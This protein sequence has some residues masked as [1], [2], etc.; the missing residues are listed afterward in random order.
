VN[1]TAEV[2]LNG[3]RLATLIGPN[4]KVIIPAASIKETNTLEVIVSNLMANR[5]IYMDKN[6][7]P[8]KKFYNT[9][10]PA[11]RGQN[12][13]NGIFTAE[14]WTPLPSGLTGPVTLTAVSYNIK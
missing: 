7:I 3:K 14:A 1:E 9:N 4:Y 6:N 2:L 8:W 11:R 10:M 5:I 13:R 12:A